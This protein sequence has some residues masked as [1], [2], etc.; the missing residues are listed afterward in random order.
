MGGANGA[1]KMGIEEMEDEET[2]CSDPAAANPIQD[3][4]VHYLNTDLDLRS[5][6][7]L[8]ALAAL[9]EACGLAEIHLRQEDDGSWFA[10]FEAG[11]CSAEPDQSITALLDVIEALAPEYRAMWSRCTVREFNLGYQC[12]DVPQPFTQRLSSEVVV[13]MAAVGASMR[14]TLYP[15]YENI[16]KQ[17]HDPEPLDESDT[18]GMTSCST[19]S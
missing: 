2:Y 8:T 4:I 5:A 7:D 13:R 14:I 16:A 6:D 10:I 3:G 19:K 15:D 12:G 18:N 11:C 9:F 17:A 1:K